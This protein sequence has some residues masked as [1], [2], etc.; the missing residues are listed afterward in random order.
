WFNR[1]GFAKVQPYY[2]RTGELHALR[3]D[4]KPFIRTYFNSLASLV[5]PEDLSMWEHFLNGAYNKTHETGYFLHQSRLMFARER[6]KELW[7]VPCITDQWLRDGMSVA[8]GNAP[9]FFGTVNYSIRSHVADGYVEAEVDVPQRKTPEIVVL[10]LR[11][12]HGRALATAD[13]EGG[14]LDRIDAES[15]TV[16]IVPQAKHLHIRVDYAPGPP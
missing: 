3:D 13:V 6:D 2:A 12:P 5:N 7:L 15:H 8:F 9:T 10:R 14:T 4:V 16:H 1:G 11:D